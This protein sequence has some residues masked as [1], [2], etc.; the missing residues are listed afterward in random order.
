MGNEGIKK[1]T[2]FA[3][4]T[5]IRNIIKKHF[6]LWNY[7]VVIDNIRQSLLVFAKIKRTRKYL[8]FKAADFFKENN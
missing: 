7:H 6:I 4:T 1:Y 8:S 5:W 3:Q 2:S